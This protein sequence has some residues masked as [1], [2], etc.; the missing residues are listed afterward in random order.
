MFVYDTITDVVCEFN[1][2][3]IQLELIVAILIIIGV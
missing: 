3:T 2:A 1:N